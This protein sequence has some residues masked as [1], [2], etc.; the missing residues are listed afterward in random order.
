MKI[1]RF[2]AENFARIVAV[3]IV[4]GEDS[5][6]TLRGLNG[7]GKSSI[8]SA[9][10]SVIEGAGQVECPIRHG[11]Q[12]ATVEVDLADKKLAELLTATRKFWWA[13]G[14]DG[15]KKLKEKLTVLWKEGG[16]GPRLSPQATLDALAGGSSFDPSE[17]LRLKPEEQGAAIQRAVG[18]DFTALDNKR[19][20]L[21]ARRTAVNAEGKA[22]KARLLAMPEPSGL[23][24]VEVSELLAEQTR[25]LDEKRVGEALKTA[26]ANATGRLTLADSAIVRA[27]KSIAQAQAALDAA[28]AE[29]ATLVQDRNIAR[30]NVADAEQAVVQA[31]DLSA[32]LAAV[33]AQIQGVEA[34]NA[35]V[36]TDVARVAIEG[37]LLA[38][39]E[40]SVS[41]SDG[42]DALDADRASQIAAAK[43]PVDDMGFG[44]SGV[45]VK[46]I[47]L[48]QAGGREGIRVAMAVGIARA[49][50]LKVVRIHEGANFDREGLALI[51]QMAHDAGAQVWLA[52]PAEGSTGFEIV[53]GELARVD[54]VAVEQVQPVLPSEPKKSRKK[55]PDDISP[56]SVTGHKML[57]GKISAKDVTPIV[58]GFEAVD[59]EKAS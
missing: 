16:A 3:E 11:Q 43:F 45:T 41:L 24:R 36:A 50:K 2:A 6:V 56:T 13:T 27:E 53:D 47:P 31:P 25:L 28:V 44:P 4:P 17:F 46:G 9:I 10:A 29:H 55:L 5:L 20:D 30:R 8:L 19:A 51:A 33:A 57:G 22:K 54:G 37:E 12:E 39:R 59:A 15:V 32:P 52:T 42:I 49:S 58:P 40:Q 23:V 48:A 21:Y 38:L 18:L 1:V 7:A 35:K 14:D 34:I 26:L